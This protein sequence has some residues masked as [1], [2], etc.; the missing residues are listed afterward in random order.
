MVMKDFVSFT[1]LYLIRPLSF[2]PNHIVNGFSCSIEVTSGPKPSISV[3]CL[4]SGLY[5][6]TPFDVTILVIRSSEVDISLTFPL[7]AKAAIT[8]TPSLR[9]LPLC[10]KAMTVPSSPPAKIVPLLSTI[11][12]LKVLE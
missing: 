7:P 3:S 12:D 8:V 2:V 9:G 6:Y 1:R 11:K 4:V 5:S 10:R